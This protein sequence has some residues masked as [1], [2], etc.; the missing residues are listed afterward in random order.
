[1]ESMEEDRAPLRRIAPLLFCAA[2]FFVLFFAQSISGRYS[3]D[4]YYA[5]FWRGGPIRFL[6]NVYGHFQ[7]FNGRVLVHLM[8]QTLLAFPQWVLAAVD[9]LWLLLM[10]RLGLQVLKGSRSG[11]GAA[12]LAAFGAGVLLVGQQVQAETLLWASGYYNYIFPIFLTVLACV[13]WSRWLDSKRVRSLVWL[14]PVQFLCGATTEQCGAMTVMAVSCLSLLWLWRERPGFRWGLSA[15]LA[16]LATLLGWGSIF[17][18]PATM[19]RADKFGS[20]T[21]DALQEGL[22]AWAGNIL[23]P[24]GILPILLL[25]CSAAVLFSVLC[26]RKLLLLGLPGAAGLL[27]Y[28]I[29]DRPVNMT[30]PLTLYLLAFLLLAALLLCKEA[31]A[32]SALLAAAVVGQ[33]VMLP[34]NTVIARGLMPSALLLILVTI[35]LLAACLRAL[36]LEEAWERRL[37]AGLACAVSALALLHFFPILTGYWGNYKIDAENEASAARSRQTG[38]P[39]EYRIDYDGRFGLDTRMYFD[40][41]FMA[42]YLEMERLSASGVRIVSQIRPRVLVRGEQL[43]SPAYPGEKEYYLP[44][45]QVMDVLGG[46]VTWR[47]EGIVYSINGI[48]AVLDYGYAAF[49]CRSGDREW[50]VETRGECSQRYYT[51]CLPQRVLREALDLNFTFDPE[52]NVYRLAED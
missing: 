35:R 40:N 15:A 12:G 42:T 8:V 43:Q 19:H 51:L 2:V 21:L 24:K 3:D 17:L 6:K 45:D 36:P 4:F 30:V 37:P 5:T 11:E 20:H 48:E 31:P 32:A 9:T 7:A 49:S 14:L 33:V 13:C 26:H 22:P 1:M 50:T 41:Y 18:S 47:E 38:E 10:G 23:S 28:P 34:T 25:F 29:L 46:T 44:V 39:F 27:L 16:P 52:E